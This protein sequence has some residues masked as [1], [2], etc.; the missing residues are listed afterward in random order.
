LCCAFIF[1][2]TF[3][4]TTEFLSGSYYPTIHHI[5]LILA[6]VAHFFCDL[7]E[8]PQYSNFMKNMFEKYKKY[9]EDIPLLYCMA[10][11]LD[12]RVKTCG[13]HSIV[14]YFYETLDFDE[15]IT[16]KQLEIKKIKD[17]TA[18]ALSEMYNLYEFESSCSS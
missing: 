1:L 3:K 9:Y 18:K 16:L 14:D 4:E 7:M 15:T 6:K 8:H 11:C 10:L 5:L 13:F 2:F 17:K 12:S